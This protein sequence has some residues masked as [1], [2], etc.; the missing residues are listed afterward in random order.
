MFRRAFFYTTFS[1]LLFLQGSL[2]AAEISQDKIGQ[3]PTV[4]IQGEI[5]SGDYNKLRSAFLELSPISP[6][7]F[8]DSP[9]GDISEAIKI[10]QLVR[11]LQTMVMVKKNKTCSSA[12]FFIYLGGA[13]RLASGSIY[14]Q[15]LPMDLAVGYVG[16][17]R[18]YL[19]SPSSS[20]ESVELQAN[21]MRKIRVY[22]DANLVPSRL[23]DTM[24]SRPSND[25]Y[26]LTDRDIEDLGEYPPELEELFISKCK[27][28]RDQ[29]K[30]VST[31][32]TSGN[33]A[34][35]LKLKKE[36]TA[37]NTCISNYMADK[38]VER[39]EKLKS[40]WQPK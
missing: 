6:L 36:N 20:D 34:L 1:F 26:W 38:G 31:A 10:G 24:M 30:R 3:V 15:P 40:G 29:I 35:F 32:R 2:H 37:I 19:A 9:G 12:C 23:I 27:Y 8:L 13:T 22:L 7:I 17:H 21:V 5:R 14:G 4:T 39:L 11:Y 33:T 25:I 16:L 18:P 28:D